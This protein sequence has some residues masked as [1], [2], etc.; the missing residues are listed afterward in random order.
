MQVVL[1]ASAAGNLVLPDEQSEPIGQ[2]LSSLGPE[3]EISVPTLW[4][5]E[6]GN[7]LIQAF[8]RKR[9]TSANI[10][11]AQQ[12]LRQIPISTDTSIGWIYQSDL[13]ASAQEYSLTVY[14]AA[15]LELAVR[16]NAKIVSCDTAL[17]AACKKAKVQFL[18]LE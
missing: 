18:R 14:D 12:L 17:L 11:E 13:L 3:D 8:R 7:I 1:D 4:W 5:F 9:I 10:D 2:F 15:Y 6:I 16:I